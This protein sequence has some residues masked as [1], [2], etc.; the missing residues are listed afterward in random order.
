MAFSSLYYVLIIFFFLSP[1]VV[2]QS[3][4]TFKSITLV[5]PVQKDSDSGLHVT[6]IH[7]RTPLLPIKLLVDLNSRFLWVN[8]EKNYS[9]FTYRTPFCRSTQ[10]ARAGN[11]YCFKCSSTARPG[12]HNNTCGVM[13]TNPITHQTALAELGQ[14]VLSIHLA[15]GSNQG[16]FVTVPQFLFACAPAKLLNGPLPEKVQGIAGLGHNPIALPSQLA[17]HFGFRPKFALCLTSTNKGNGLIFFG[18]GPYKLIPG[19]DV[20][21]PVGFTPIT[22]GPKGE[23]YIKVTSIKIDNKPVPFNTST[24]SNNKKG[25]FTYAMISTTTPYTL[26]ETPIFRAVTQF[27]ASRLIWAP[28]VPPISPFGVCFNSTN[29][30]WSRV[31]PAVSNIELVLQN[32]N[33]TWRVV[34]AN[35]MV[36]VRPDVLCLGFVDGGLNPRTPIVIGTHQLENNLLQFDLA[37]SRLGFSSSLLLRRVSCANFNFTTTP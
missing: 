17:S 28:R 7:K 12:C 27:F 6:N 3:R 34:G 25:S 16:S 23:Y 37:K 13:T 19:M 36:E 22:V 31:G 32:E 10:C 33:V 14:D 1:L 35:S 8:C 21:K 4:T 20:S 18:S 15:H 29:L 2:S 26:L 24:F 30:A 5:L 11:H 9:S